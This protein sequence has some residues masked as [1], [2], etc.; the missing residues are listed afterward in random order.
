MDR[1]KWLNEDPQKAKEIDL[2]KVI[3][4]DWKANVDKASF[5]NDIWSTSFLEGKGQLSHFVKEAIK[6]FDEDEV[7]INRRAMIKQKIKSRYGW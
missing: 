2:T 6:T 7:T 1:I 4:K 3:E 5:Q